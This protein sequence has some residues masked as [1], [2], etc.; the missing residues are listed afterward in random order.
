MELVSEGLLISM[1]LKRTNSQGSE[2]KCATVTAFVNF[3]QKLKERKEANLSE[4]KTY[5]WYLA[6]KICVSNTFLSIQFTVTIFEEALIVR[7][8]EMTLI[9]RA[10]V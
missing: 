1:F 7:L 10:K 6:F 8:L 3:L 4:A 5:F 2:K 9:V